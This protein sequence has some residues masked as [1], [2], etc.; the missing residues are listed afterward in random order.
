MPMNVMGPNL[1][2]W[3]T[4][5]VSVSHAEV[6]DWY[7]TLWRR[8]VRKSAIQGM[9][10]ALTPRSYIQ[11]F[12]GKSMINTIKSLGE[13]RHHQRTHSVTLISTPVKDMQDVQLNSGWWRN[14]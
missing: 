13:I 4:P 10:S 5:Q 9:I 8:D 7:C 1:V 11:T 2:T 12:D 3:G 14:L 6:T